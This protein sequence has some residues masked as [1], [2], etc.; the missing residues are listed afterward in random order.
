MMLVDM[1]K[2]CGGGGGF[3]INS[4]LVETF[5]EENEMTHQHIFYYTADFDI[6]QS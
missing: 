3:K 4:V 5:A 2:F 6:I 1:S